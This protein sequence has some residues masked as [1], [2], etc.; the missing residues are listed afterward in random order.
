MERRRVMEMAAGCANCDPEEEAVG[1]KTW[2][3]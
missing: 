2:D 1:G 3:I